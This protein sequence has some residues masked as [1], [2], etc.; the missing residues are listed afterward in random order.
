MRTLATLPTLVLS[1]CW[2]ASSAAAASSDAALAVSVEGA[3]QVMAD[4]TETGLAAT[5]FMKLRE[6]DQIHVP[7]GGSLEIIYM[8][9]GRRETWAGPAELSIHAEGTKT[10]GATPARVTELG[11]QVAEGL[12]A[13]P[14]LLKQAERTRAG[15]A[16]VRGTASDEVALSDEELATVDSARTLY[17]RLKKGAGK[18]DILPEMYLAGVLLEYGIASEATALLRRAVRKCGGCDAPKRLLEY[19]RKK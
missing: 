5:A 14:V 10:Q 15:Q 16:L 8:V 11:S 19:A 1:L 17:N 13:V 18:S 7:S 9:S 2:L 12:Q 3:V 6:G 4:E